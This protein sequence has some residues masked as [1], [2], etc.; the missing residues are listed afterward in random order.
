MSESLEQIIKETGA[1]RTTVELLLK[2]T[3]GDIEAVRKIFQAIPKDYIVFKI[4][5]MGHKTH[6]YGS[7]LFV[8]NINNKEIEEIEI[9]L[10]SD[11]KASEIDTNLKYEDFKEAII[12]FSQKSETNFEMIERLKENIKSTEFKNILS[13]S[14][15]YDGNVNANDIKIAL[16]EM[17]FKVL[18]EPSAAIKLDT[19]RID[20][21]RFAKK[22]K[23]EL[24]E[25]KKEKPE[26]I[27]TKEE[28]KEKVEKREGV[29]IRSISLVLLKIEPV[30]SPVK[31]VPITDLSI[32]DE[33][34]VR[35]TD[36]REIGDYL[37]GLL[38]GKEGEN[39]IPVKAIVK[40]VEKSPD[41]ENIMLMVEFGPGI[42]GRCFVPEG[43]KVLTP[44]SEE[45]AEMNKFS[46][47]FSFNPIWIIIILIIL[48]I[49]FV[50]ITTLTK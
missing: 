34:M 44:I 26:E 39:R 17:F 47:L 27:K 9:V 46:S 18:T 19:E 40:K 23:L 25:E 7:M 42:A 16:S 2:F 38:G 12:Q 4:R 15:T 49:L 45:L 20:V 10:S 14:V 30:L 43:I 6:N 48:F 13:K 33:I 31:G 22:G 28:E 37:A 41:T 5:F 36:E 24:K 11:Q 35:I 50:I 21:L 29:E 32:G 3:G 8:M 1:D